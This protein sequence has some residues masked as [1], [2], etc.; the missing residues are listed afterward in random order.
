[1]GILLPSHFVCF[2]SGE[3]N[4]WGHKGP[5]TWHLTPVF[6]NV[7]S[8]LPAF[9]Q[10]AGLPDRHHLFVCLQ[11]D[12]AKLLPCAVLEIQAGNVKVRQH[13]VSEG[14][15][16][17]NCLAC[18]KIILTT[19]CCVWARACVCVIYF[20]A[21]GAIFLATLKWFGSFYSPWVINKRHIP[22]SLQ[23]DLPFDVPSHICHSL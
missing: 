1:M 9:R 8:C 2:W 11:C 14:S 10:A 5:W 20:C 15:V 17:G 19:P 23:Q 13:R 22:G 6:V 3:V 12:R 16:G 18:L 7:P 4:L 21:E